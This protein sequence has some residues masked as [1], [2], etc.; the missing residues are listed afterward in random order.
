MET[1]P[2]PLYFGSKQDNAR[3]TEELSKILQSTRKHLESELDKTEAEKTHLSVQIQVW[4]RKYDQ[5]VILFVRPHSHMHMHIE[6][7]V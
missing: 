3:T 7:H 2:H 5:V 4:T 1:H 6:L